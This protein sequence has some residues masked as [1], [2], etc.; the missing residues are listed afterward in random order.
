MSYGYAASRYVT[1]RETADMMAMSA[2]C[3]QRLI[4]YRDG[5][6]RTDMRALRL[7]AVC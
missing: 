5:V 2:Q 3:A 4:N 1:R 6:Q 7:F